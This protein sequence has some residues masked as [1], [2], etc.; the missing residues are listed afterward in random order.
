M[1]R[2]TEKDIAAFEERR[3][4]WEKEGTVRT[5][6]LIEPKE[7]IERKKGRGRVSK[8][9]NI[10]TEV[11]G[12]KFDSRREA[13]RWMVLRL[14]ERAGEIRDLRRQVEYPLTVN[15]MTVAVYRADFT[16]LRKGELVVEDSKGFRTEVFRLKAKLMLACHGVVVSES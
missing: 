1:M 2:W 4:E 12:M 13:R 10:R 8:Y 16:Y 3:K 7:K 9:G 6:K 14:E 5:H 15:G 11:K